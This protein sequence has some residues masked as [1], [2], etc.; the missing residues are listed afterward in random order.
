M[1]AWIWRH[2]PFGLPGKL[3]GSVLLAGG[4]MA[5]LWFV[6]FPWADPWI[7]QTLLPWNEGQLEGE[8]DPGEGDAPPAPGDPGLTDPAEEDDGLVGPDGS[9]LE[10]EHDIPYDTDG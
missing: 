10:D 9:T 6:V 3:F 2:L 8:F 4:A 5:M 1:Y 7:E